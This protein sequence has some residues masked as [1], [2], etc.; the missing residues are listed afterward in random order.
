[1]RALFR[2]L[3]LASRK[4]SAVNSATGS[5]S[6]SADRAWASGLE[7]S[8]SPVFVL[9]GLRRKLDGLVPV[10]AVI[11]GERWVASLPMSGREP[12]QAWLEK[13][14]PRMVGEDDRIAAKAEGE[15][16]LSPARV[17]V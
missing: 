15:A 1:M 16:I 13:E 5:R 14:A 9:G 6:G 17:P 4:G 3:A 12:P 8:G 11:S 7:P 10:S 2:V